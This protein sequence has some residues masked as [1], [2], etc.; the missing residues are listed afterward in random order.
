MTADPTPTT[1]QLLQ[2]KL[3]EAG[4]KAWPD[5]AATTGTSAN[6]LRKIAYGDRTNPRIDTIEPLLRHFNLELQ[7]GEVGSA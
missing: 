4:A 5:I 6:T 1:M 2:R 3:R 7:C